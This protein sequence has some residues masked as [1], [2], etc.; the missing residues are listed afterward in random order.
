MC[1]CARVQVCMN[2]KCEH[3][4]LCACVISVQL[5]KC[6]GVHE[7]RAKGVAF[8]IC[9]RLACWICHLL[10]SVCKCA[11][12]GVC[13]C[14]WAACQRSSFLDL[15]QAGRLDQPPLVMIHS[16]RGE[17]AP[18]LCHH[19]QCNQLHRHR[20]IEN[21][22]LQPLQGRVKTSMTFRGKKLTGNFRICAFHCKSVVCWT[23]CARVWIA[24]DFW[25]A[26][27]REIWGCVCTQ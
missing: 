18:S 3:C 13:K 15:Q 8:W 24:A 22:N 7:Q 6:A 10:S 17:I 5:C 20:Y 23:T 27:C 12:M 2:C 25:W 21:K 26:K 16:Q 19:H 11:S 14:A 4:A 9:S 1:K